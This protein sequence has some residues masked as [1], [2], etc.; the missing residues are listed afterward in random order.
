VKY[1]EILDLPPGK[2]PWVMSSYT[3]TG[4]YLTQSGLMFCDPVRGLHPSQLL[5]LDLFPTCIK[6]NEPNGAP[7]ISL[8][9]NKL[10]DQMIKLADKERA[11]MTPSAL[12]YI[13]NK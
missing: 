1:I 9:V 3:Q 4:F 2:D 6:N 10:M 5:S 11:I 13:C 8:D 12:D 7:G